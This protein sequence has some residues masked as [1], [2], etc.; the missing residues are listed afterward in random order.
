MARA[1][2]NKVRRGKAREMRLCDL[3]NS[4]TSKLFFGHMNA[5]L[6][7]DDKASELESESELALELESESELENAKTSNCQI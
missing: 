2:R 3:I 4:R 5:W 7:L 1:R 6:G